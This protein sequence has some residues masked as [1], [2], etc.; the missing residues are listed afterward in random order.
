MD[1]SLLNPGD[2]IQ[3][4]V[5][6][7]S[8]CLA[9]VRCMLIVLPFVILVRGVMLGDWAQALLFALGTAVGLVP[10]MLPVVT[11]VCLSGSAR[12]LKDRHVIVKNVDAM[13][14]LG[15][16]DVVCV[17]KRSLKPLPKEKEDKGQKARNKK[18]PVPSLYRGRPFQAFTPTRW[19]RWAWGSN[20]T[21]RGRCRGP[22][23]GCGR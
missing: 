9:L 1:A 12:R 23:P 20:R 4:S 11:S 7:K 19:C 8:V 3:Y 21:Q 22:R 16:M 17:D 13:E 5:S 18:R 14:A 2:T 6:A 15:S 10:E